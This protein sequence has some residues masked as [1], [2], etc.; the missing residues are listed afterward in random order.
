LR[1]NLGIQF[2]SGDPHAG[3]LS[4]SADS[5]GL[6]PLPPTPKKTF[7]LKF[8]LKADKVAIAIEIEAKPRPTGLRADEG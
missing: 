8:K 2:S 4:G 1:R 3:T 7:D 6:R 5:F